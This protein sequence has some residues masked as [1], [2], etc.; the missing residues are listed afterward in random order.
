MDRE[1]VSTIL[2]NVSTTLV[3]TM[4][5]PIIYMIYEQILISIRKKIINEKVEIKIKEH[6]ILFFV[7]L[8][9]FIL[10]IIIYETASQFWWRDLDQGL[11]IY[12]DG[13][14]IM[15]PLLIFILSLTLPI[16]TMFSLT[17]PQKVMIRIVKILLYIFSGYIIATFSYTLMSIMKS[18]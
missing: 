16:I 7:R 5:V 10:F 2:S 4:Y 1:I 17:W 15:N 13:F 14:H 9:I 6:Y 18:V 3:L 8:I 11:L 12:F